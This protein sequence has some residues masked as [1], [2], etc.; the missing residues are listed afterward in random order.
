MKIMISSSVTYQTVS[1][2][3]LDPQ[4]LSV[5][6]HTFPAP[7]EKF[8]KSINALMAAS[9]SGVSFRNVERSQFGLPRPLIE[10][11]ESSAFFFSI[12]CGKFCAQKNVVKRQLG[13]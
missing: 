10:L 2:K 1:V 3:A 12:I 6:E 8:R 5:T 13:L 11:S 7:S 4:V 9:C